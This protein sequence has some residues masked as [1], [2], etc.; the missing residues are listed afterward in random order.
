MTL[1]GVAWLASPASALSSWGVSVE[2]GAVYLGRRYGVLFLGYAV[3]LWCGR[4]LESPPARRAI[5]LGNAV[6]NAGMM[7]AS[8]WGATT[9]VVAPSVWGAA[10]VEG[11]LATAFG[12]YYV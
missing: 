12:Y 10:V 7:L 9:R 2:P 5:L 8:M 6:V 1:L 4:G 3:I 11:M